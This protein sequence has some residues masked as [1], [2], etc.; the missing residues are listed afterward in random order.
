MLYI[1]VL[2]LGHDWQGKCSLQRDGGLC[3]CVC[4]YVCLSVSLLACTIVPCVRVSVRGRS[5]VACRCSAPTGL[6]IGGLGGVV[7]CVCVVG[8]YLQIRVPRFF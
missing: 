5:G 8:T 3:A 6:R 2:L 7:G 4:V 1:H